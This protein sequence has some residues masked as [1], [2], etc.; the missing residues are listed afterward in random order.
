M[1]NFTYPLPIPAIVNITSVPLSIIP[2]HPL[3]STTIH[4]FPQS[5]NPL[6][7]KNKYLV[8]PLR[9]PTF[10][11]G[12]YTTFLFPPRL[13]HDHPAWLGSESCCETRKNQNRNRPKIRFVKLVNAVHSCTY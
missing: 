7:I 10:G 3:S 13:K 2:L 12:F 8:G 6:Y 4:L 9:L 5:G 1:V 11:F